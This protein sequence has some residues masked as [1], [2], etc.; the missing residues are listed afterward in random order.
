VKQQLGG[1]NFGS[2]FLGEWNG[3]LVAVK[4]LNNEDAFRKFE[5]EASI[6]AKLSHPNVVQFLGIYN[7]VSGS[8]WLVTEYLPRGSLL[9]VLSSHKS[10]L[11]VMDL[12]NMSINAT[13]GMCYLESVGIVHRDLA[14]RNLLVTT[15]YTVKVGDFGLSRVTT[16]YQANDTSKIPVKWTAPEVLEGNPHTSRSDVWS[17]GVVLWEIFSFGTPPYVWL[18]N[19]EAVEVIPKGEILTQPLNCPDSIYLLMLKC[20]NRGPD[21]RPTFLEILNRLKAIKKEIL[22]QSSQLKSYNIFVT[23]E[24]SPVLGRERTESENSYS[25]TP[26]GNRAKSKASLDAEELERVRAQRL[27]Q[28]QELRDSVLIENEDYEIVNIDDQD[29]D[30]SQDQDNDDGP[31]KPDRK[32]TS[33]SPGKRRTATS[34]GKDEYHTQDYQERNPKQVPPSFSDYGEFHLGRASPGDEAEKSE[35]DYEERLHRTMPS[36]EPGHLDETES[37][38]EQ[39]QVD[40]NDSYIYRLN[41]V[42][43]RDLDS[44][45]SH[46]EEDGQP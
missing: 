23:D 31:S 45:T 37:E 19:K 6:L 20:W 11:K 30:R 12:I 18:S 28:Q 13:S 25:K 29:S 22:A 38:N 5:R 4:R 27:Q 24:D 26:T 1:G 44:S 41:K 46:S 16:S 14:A 32:G 3:T 17:L 40:G 21:E 36:S 34:Q 9:D 2:V 35:S 10:S 43:R 42:K 33:S 8:S 7:D 15:D 39:N